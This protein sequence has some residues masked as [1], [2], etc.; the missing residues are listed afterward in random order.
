V[1]LSARSHLVNARQLPRNEVILRPG[2]ALITEQN[3]VEN[4]RVKL[5]MRLGRMINLSRG[6][7]P[8]LT[9][10]FIDLSYFVHKLA[11]NA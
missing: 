3:V 6:F 7:L 11:E 1:S 10:L 2:R 8:N 5:I 9:W 4:P